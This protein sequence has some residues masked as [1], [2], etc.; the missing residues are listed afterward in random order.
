MR[1][2]FI[3]SPS[4]ISA[5]RTMRRLQSCVSSVNSYGF[6]PPCTPPG[7]AAAAGGV[8]AESFSNRALHQHACVEARASAASDYD[9]RIRLTAFAIC[10]LGDPAATSCRN[11]APCSPV[12]AMNFYRLAGDKFVEERGQPGLV[13]ATANRR[14]PDR[15]I[16]PVRAIRTDTATN[17]LKGADSAD[18]ATPS[19]NAEDRSR[20]AGRS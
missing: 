10:R 5:A 7:R 2:Y 1:A 9:G 12:Q 17:G 4:A 14:S 15:L 13:A 3:G 19:V 16:S 8:H 6:G 18:P 20:P 11:R